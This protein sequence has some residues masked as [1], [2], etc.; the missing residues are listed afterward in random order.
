MLQIRGESTESCN[1]HKNNM[2]CTVY[3][4]CSAAAGYCNPY[5]MR[6]DA[7]KTGDEQT[8]YESE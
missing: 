8:E 2:S 5:T 6:Y 7:H 3:C 4:A 1:C